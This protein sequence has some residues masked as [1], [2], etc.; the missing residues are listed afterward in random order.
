MSTIEKLE[1]GI[2]SSSPEETMR[3]AKELAL[4]APDEALITLSGDLGAGKT[5]LR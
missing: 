3:I 1:N 2:G 4:H 5:T